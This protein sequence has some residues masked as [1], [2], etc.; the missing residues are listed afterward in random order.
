SLHKLSDFIKICLLALGIGLLSAS[1]TEI[2]DWL[3]PSFIDA[4]SFSQNLA[5][6]ILGIVVVTPLLLVWRSLPDGWP[7][8][9]MSA[10]AALIIGLSFLVGQVLFLDWFHD[11]LGLVARG[12]WMYLFITW[13]AIR[14]GLHGTVLI[15]AITA[16]QGIVGAQKHLGFFANDIEATHLANYFFYILILSTVGMAL[17]TYLLERKRALAELKQHRD[18][19]EQQVQARTEDLQHQLQEMVTLNHRLEETQNQLLQSEKM[20]S[21]GQLA[22]GVAH[23]INNPVGFITSNLGSLKKYVED[24]FEILAAYET[25]I[26]PSATPQALTRLAE[27]KTEKEFD[28]IQTDVVELLRESKSGL[29]RVKKI[30]LDLK[31]FSHVSSNVFEL[32]DIHECIE[33]TLNIVWNELKY[34]C[35]VT[36]NFDP[37]LPKISCRP[38]QLSQVFMNL[39]VNAAQAIETK[40]VITITTR[41]LAP[42]SIQVIVHDT[43]KGIP[44][45]NIKRIFDP[46]FTTKPVGEGT[47]LGLSLAYGIINS[48][49]G[50]IDI[51]SEVGQGTQFTLTLPIVAIEQGL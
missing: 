17:A 12:Y 3:V 5:G 31:S 11:S 35:E 1:T 33:S 21:L 48:H 20:A 10:E 27:L 45:E 18:Q 19:L 50:K 41:C 47:G 22:A 43:G 25:A 8:F 46:F 2:V 29:E 36:R 15:L 23:E 28:F 37:A 30:V 38:S 42:D 6:H 39:L 14:L 40:G 32:A 24:V 16:A 51:E 34:K 4:H 49:R 9:W 7:S 44:P 26:S 13:A